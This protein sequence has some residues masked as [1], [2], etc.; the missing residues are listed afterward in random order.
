VWV[1]D[2]SRVG[3]ISAADDFKA[4]SWDGKT[5]SPAHEWSDVKVDLSKVLDVSGECALWSSD[6]GVCVGTPEGRV[7][8]LTEGRMRYVKG[9]S[10]A[11]VATD[12]YIIN[13]V[14]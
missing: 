5:Q 6:E 7:I 10:G 4:M 8:N 13:S 12:D 9:S 1:S 14:W 3:F 2:S 11:I